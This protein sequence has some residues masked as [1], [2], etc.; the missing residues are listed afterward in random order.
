M[1]RL[2]TIFFLF[3]LI[4]ISS[5]KKEPTT[6]ITDW[7]IPLIKDTLT[8][9]NWVDSGFVSVNTGQSLDIT[10]KRELFSFDINEYVNI[11]DTTV[12]Q[13]FVIPVPSIFASPGANFV[14]DVDEFTFDLDDVE[15]RQVVVD[16]G[17]ALVEIIN[18][19]DIP[20][21]FNI[22]LPGVEK[23]GNVFQTT[24]TVPAMLNGVLGKK[25]FTIDFSGYTLDLT[26]ELGNSFN[27]LQSIMQV[28]SSPDGP[29]TL[30]TDTDI[31]TFTFSLSDIEL[32]YARGYFGN[33]I[34]EDAQNLDLD[35]LNRITSGSID[36]ENVQI[37]LTLENGIKAAGQ[38]KI[39]T[40]SSFNSNQNTS[41]SLSNQDIGVLKNINPA[42]G[43][44]STLTPSLTAYS[45]SSSNSNI[46][47]FI[48]NLGSQYTVDYAV[49][50]NPLGNTSGGFDEIFGNSKLALNLEATMPLQL[51]VNQLVFTDTLDFDF[52]QSTNQTKVIEGEIRV[53]TQNSFPF[54]GQ[55]IIGLLDENNVLLT[56]LSSAEN[57][58]EAYSTTTTIS[59]VP[60][61]ENSLNYTLSNTQLQMLDKTKKII[62][63][64]IL[65]A[66][67]GGV[68]TVYAD[69]QLIIDLF[70]NFNVQASF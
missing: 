15:L 49:E 28:S 14:N 59:P 19:L 3:F 40:I 34:L 24:E 5:C 30:I 35:I 8:F 60:L 33:L 63:T 38:A 23:D 20:A 17:V 4:S 31:F 48:E 16:A 41:V 25:Q 66:S 10:Y 6:W 22:T 67:A 43:S 2:K 55:L 47:Q 9:D 62:Y 61:V 53:E 68:Q 13:N 26:G 29:S 11:P 12:E 32:S 18:P 27:K 7:S 51:G 37:A 50:L 46:E 42:T 54:S 64:A 56:T 36:V 39:N 70:T 1:M 57:I 52:N 21:I 44:W 45:F 69:S 65:D 58:A